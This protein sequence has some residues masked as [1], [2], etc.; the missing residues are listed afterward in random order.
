MDPGRQDIE[1]L[2]R[3]AESAKSAGATDM[4]HMDGPAAAINYV[5]AADLVASFCGSGRLHGPIL[6]WG[7][8]YG[9]V[10]LLLQRRGIKVL[11]YDVGRRGWIDRIPELSDLRIVYGED[12]VKLP[13]ESGSFRAAL[14]VGVLEHVPDIDGSLEEINRILAPSGILFLLMFPNRFSWAEKLAE[15]R[16][17]SVH[18]VKFTAASTSEL[19]TRHGFLTEKLWRRNFLPKNLTGL[20]PRIKHAY[21]KF[22]RQVEMLDKILANFPPT[23]YFSGV[24]EFI[25]RK[26]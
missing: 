6:D 22:Y 20:S 16:Q 14:S 19:L 8:G 7:C 15:W 2:M 23:S 5:R 3:M 1:L 11:S 12:P 4:E 24:L 17:R 21:G 13:Y 26:S 18:P 25:A 9:Q 10:S